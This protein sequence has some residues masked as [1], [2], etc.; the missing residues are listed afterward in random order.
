MVRSTSALQSP[1]SRVIVTSRPGSRAVRRPAARGRRSLTRRTSSTAVGGQRGQP[2]AGADH[3]P[4]HRCDRVAVAAEPGGQPHRAPRLV[5]RRGRHGEGGRHRL[6]GREARP[7]ETV[8]RGRAGRRRRT[9]RVRSSA[10]PI[11]RATSAPATCWPCVRTDR[12]RA[13]A[14]RH[15]IVPARAADAGTDDGGHRGGSGVRDGRV[16]G[17]P[18]EVGDRGAQPVER[19]GWHRDADRG[20]PHGGAV[21]VAPAPRRTGRCAVGHQ[22]QRAQG[23]RTEQVGRAGRHHRVLP[24]EQPSGQR[25]RV[26]ACRGPRPAARPR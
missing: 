19:L 8:D 14:E 2:G 3:R 25:V 23:R 12:R 7:D 22:P 17:Q 6:L 5:R 21:R 1:T 4:G 10:Q 13:Y 11:R 18:V 15:G 16:V 24:G 20:H 26:D 9:P